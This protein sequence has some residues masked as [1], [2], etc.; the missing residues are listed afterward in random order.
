M[1]GAHDMGGM[2]GFGPVWAQPQE[3]VFHSAWERRVFAFTLAMNFSGSWT[4]DMSRSARESLHPAGYL[5]RS[6]YAIWLAGLEKLLAERELVSGEEIAARRPLAA[7]RPVPRVLAA[8]DVAD[9]L[10]KGTPYERPASAPPRFALGTRVRARNMHPRTHTRLP[11]YVR[12]HIG[13][14]EHVRGHHVFPDASARGATD[15]AHWLYSVRFE[16]TE[17]W[18]EDSDPKVRVFVEMWEP[19]LEPA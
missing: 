14:I 19:Y 18:G 1:N 8:P 4:A 16:G 5:A 12:G 3:P 9:V 10:A 7:A 6:Y 11:R 13:R 2:H 17:L 15:V